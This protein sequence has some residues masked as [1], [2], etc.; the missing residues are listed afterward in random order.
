MQYRLLGLV[1]IA[2]LVVAGGITFVML[3]FLGWSYNFRLT[4]A[5]VT[6]VIFSIGVTADSFIVYFER[7][8]DEVC[9]GRPLVAAVDAGWKRARQTNIGGKKSGG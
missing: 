5:G 9:D 4:M 6:G 8:R 3:T 1:T 2:S 7:V